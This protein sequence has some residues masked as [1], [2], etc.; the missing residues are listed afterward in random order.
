MPTP[1]SH[2]LPQSS[3]RMSTS[4][5]LF[6]LMA[7]TLTTAQLTTQKP[8]GCYSMKSKPT[9][10]LT[11][12]AMNPALCSQSCGKSRYVL[13]APLPNNRLSF[14]CACT[15]QLPSNPS[16]VACN[17]SCPGS[18]TIPGLTCGGFDESGEGSIAWSLYPSSTAA[19]TTTSTKSMKVA[20]VPPPAPA[21]FPGAAVATLSDSS[22]SS[23]PPFEPV[24]VPNPKPQPQEASFMKSSNAFTSSNSNSDNE[25]SASAST[26]ESA[27][28]ID[29]LKATENPT[30]EEQAP[31]T[32]E[33]IQHM[34]K[35]TAVS[36]SAMASEPVAKQVEEIVVSPAFLA[37]A[38]GSLAIFFGMFSVA[39]RRR[40]LR[41]RSNSDAGAPIL[42]Q[43]VEKENMDP[44]NLLPPIRAHSVSSSFCRSSHTLAASTIDMNQI[45]SSENI[46]FGSAMRSVGEPPSNSFTSESFSRLKTV[47]EISITVGQ[48]APTL[49]VLRSNFKDSEM[50]SLHSHTATED[51][52]EDD[53]KIDDTSK[54]L[55]L[56][57]STSLMKRDN[58]HNHN[59]NHPVP[60]PRRRRS[61][62]NRWNE[63]VK[64]LDNNN[65]SR[66]SLASNSTSATNSPMSPSS[67]YIRRKRTSAKSG[68]SSTTSRAP[69]SLFMNVLAYNLVQ[70]AKM[71]DEANEI[72]AGAPAVKQ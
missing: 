54:C 43:T 22:S 37:G 23:R 56:S 12:D 24:F 55:S 42:P 60:P 58:N 9:V 45:G 71:E 7:T 30:K 18:N 39:Y 14:Y 57:R 33:T 64:N 16:R 49:G 46:R 13:I 32:E 50:A 1:R 17:D 6:L 62:K 70:N 51:F 69:S 38:S 67:L 2:S 53:S 48:S 28:T 44:N 63:R 41:A 25:A 59:H 72:G 3:Y 20:A 36:N 68:V 29:K 52:E 66:F 31:Q 47:E 35:P 21:V 10:A 8:L 65:F 40:R 26:S 19:T 5:L 61:R 11:S 34:K 27:S 4:A 15:S